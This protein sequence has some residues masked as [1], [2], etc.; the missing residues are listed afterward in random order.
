MMLDALYDAHM[1]P[2]EPALLPPGDAVADPQATGWLDALAY[3]SVLAAG[4][5]AQLPKL[6]KE[7][8]I[9]EPEP[10]DTAV[11]IGLGAGL[12]EARDPS[13]K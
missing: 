12:I 6:L 9:A 10:K 8:L 5:A 7:N 4:V 11:A 3:S 2:D 13:T 1:S